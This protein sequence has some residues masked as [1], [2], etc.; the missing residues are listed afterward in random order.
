MNTVISQAAPVWEMAP[1]FV[2]QLKQ[3]EYNGKQSWK[4][5]SVV[6]EEHQGIYLL[7]VTVILS[8]NVGSVIR[9]IN[10]IHIPVMLNL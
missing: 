6:P 4:S 9:W 3:Q 7:I 5:W 1:M 2:I 10:H 8:L